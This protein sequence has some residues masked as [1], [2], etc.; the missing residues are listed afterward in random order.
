MTPT[1]FLLLSFLL[2]TLPS[3]SLPECELFLD[4]T[5]A[6]EQSIKHGLHTEPAN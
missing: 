2:F 3:C 5:I 1:L 6:I 4:E